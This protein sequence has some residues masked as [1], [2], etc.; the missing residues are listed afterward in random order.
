MAYG[1]GTPQTTPQMRP[2]TN[3]GASFGDNPSFGRGGQ[4]LPQPAGEAN[5][6]LWAQILKQYQDQMG[7][8]TGMYDQ[9]LAKLAEMQKLYDPT[10]GQK[11]YQD[12]LAMMGDVPHQPRNVM[13]F[14]SDNPY[15]Y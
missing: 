4:L 13:S 12:Q 15:G 6:D 10:L 11:Q 8:N 1:Y 2:A 9:M 3:P 5:D 7:K 14:F